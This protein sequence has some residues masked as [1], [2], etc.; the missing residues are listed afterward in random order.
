MSQ[1]TL[2]YMDVR[3]LAAL[4][5]RGPQAMSSIT[6]MSSQLYRPTT[7]SSAARLPAKRLYNDAGWRSSAGAV[8][9]SQGVDYWSRGLWRSWLTGSSG[10]PGLLGLMNVRPVAGN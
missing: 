9:V 3:Y 8:K 10:L 2:N 6:K 4:L 7:W 5:A 1:F